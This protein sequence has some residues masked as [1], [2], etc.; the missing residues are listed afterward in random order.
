M[1]KPKNIPENA[2]VYLFKDKKGTVIYV[3]KAK[4]LKNRVSSYFSNSLLPKTAQMIQN[5]NSISFINVSSEFEA[6]LLEAN[7]IKKYKPKY[8][9]ALK[10]DKSPLYIGITNEKLPRVIT[11]RKSEIKN[12]DLKA[13]NIFGPYLSGY[14]AKG[15]LS[16]IRKVFPF[17]THL[18]SEKICIYKQIGL[19]DPCP[20][21]VNTK[22]LRNKYLKNVRG[23]KNILNGKLGTVKKD[24]ES[25]I[26]DYS[27]EEKFE[28]AAKI[29][30]QL[31]FFER[32]TFTPDFE[33][34]NYLENPNL[35]ED[36]RQEEL[37]SLKKVLIQ[38]LPLQK[39]S[40]IECFDVAHLA[41]SFPTASMVTL[42]N[43]EPEKRFY[44]HFKVYQKKKNS[45]VDSMREIITRRLKHLGDWG[46]PDLIIIDGGKPQLSKVHDLL[47]E[48]EIPFIGLAKQ[49][50]TIVILKDKKFYE[51]RANGA[52]LR[53]L[54]RIRDEA[55]RFAR[56]LH[57]KQVSASLI[58]NFDEGLKERNG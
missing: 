45:D 15:V 16:R 19:C 10:D 57:H 18:P 17:S 55:H 25:Q 6:L 34:E 43:G 48:K 33:I 20:S 41:G 23:V 35:L 37:E 54:Q 32:L 4:N 24:L 53:L 13:K 44:R 11:L 46:V 42:I 14:A 47:E 1:E 22:E 50:E 56:R 36:I 3:G 21:E 9:I 51:V 2:G 30:R 7:L 29:K 8:N 31:E 40:R 5:A 49:F 27:K 38:F 28:E 12:W 39:L 52:N 58:S 26:K